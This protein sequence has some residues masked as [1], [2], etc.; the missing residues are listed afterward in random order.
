MASFPAL[1]SQTTGS[2]SSPEG[3]SKS[4]PELLVRGD[5]QAPSTIHSLQPPPGNNIE[6]AT[7]IAVAFVETVN[8][9]FKGSDQSK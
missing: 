1:P 5:Q 9:F 7:P 6:R 3:D 4:T 2:A 8:A